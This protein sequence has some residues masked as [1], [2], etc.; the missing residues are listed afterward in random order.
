MDIIVE[1]SYIHR[2]HS[3]Y[4]AITMNQVKPHNAW[5]KGA[6]AGGVP[7]NQLLADLATLV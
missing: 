1:I 6:T 7:W 5:F 3:G 2:T 4:A